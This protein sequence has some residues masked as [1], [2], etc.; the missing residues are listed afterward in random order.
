M[1]AFSQI[2]IPH[3]DIL[4]GKLTLDVFAADIW[5]VLSGKAPADYLDRD[6]FFSKTYTTKGLKNILD[7]AKRRLEGRG[8]DSVIQL[9]TP[10][11]G[12]KTHALIALYHQARKW[13]AKVC[14]FDGTALN[15]KES[16]PWEELEKQITG[17]VSITKGEIAPGKEKLIDLI[18]RNQ[19]VLILIDEILEY[20]TKAAGIRIGASNLA[21]QTMAF[22]Q[23]LS[24]AVGTVEKALLVLS[25]PSSI[26]EHYDENAEKLYGMLQKITGRTE[27]IYTPVEE[28]EIEHVIRKRLFQK[29]DE[30]AVKKVVDEFI[31]YA[32]TEGLLSQDEVQ[33]YREKFISSYPFKPEVVDVLYKK[34]GSFP[35]FQRTRGVLR[36]LSLVIFDLMDKKMPF[37]RLG[38]F[39]LGNNEIR[40][41]L[42][43]HIG[44][45][46]DSIIAQDITSSQAGSRFVDENIGNAYR[47]Y[48]LG[49]VVART[50]FMHS[51]SGKGEKGAGVREIK[52]S[53]SQPE[54]SSSVIDSVINGLREK[55][56]Y[57]ADEG[58]Y[59]SN[60]PNLN[61]VL[62]TREENI[63][64]EAIIEEERAY[65]EKFISKKGGFAVYIWAENHRDIPDTPELK[66]II[67]KDRKPEWEF[68]EK[69]GETPRIY[70][71]TLIFLAPDLNQR[72]IFHDYVRKLLALKSVDS[73]EK[74]SL[75]EGQKREIKNKIKNQ[76]QRAY[77][78]LR[79]CYRFVYLPVRND[80]KEVDL[81]FA[82]FGEAFIDKEIYNRLRNEGEI[83]ERL[84]AAV[85][86]EKYLQEKDSLPTK[87]LLESLW[88][89]PGEVR[90]TSAEGFKE[91]IKEGV[92]RGIFGLGFIE[93][94]KPV[95]KF[96]KQAVWP[97][98]S[99][100]E[101]ILKAELC[102]LAAGPEMP[103]GIVVGVEGKE[104]KEGEKVGEVEK[105]KEVSKGPI[106]KKIQLRLEIP[107][108]RLS[109]VARV[110]N[111]INTKF[112]NC[113]IEIS[114]RAEGGEISKSEYE[115]KVK[116]ALHQAAINIKEEDVD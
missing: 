31:S 19:P 30:V 102:R 9:Q 39:D 3:S 2:A 115:D 99:D 78:E 50:I 85:I 66:L 40:R 95:C 12:G 60:Q 47:A 24:G 15:P 21:A 51:F 34:W 44:S 113:H 22:L 36:L 72:P 23:E 11:G 13:G 68:V 103:R 49:T 67:L 62:L 64:R 48:K 58:L 57:L 90:L 82:T 100:G 79:K 10:F 77:E 28:D 33:R 106:I 5:Q 88:K 112:N 59:F 46:W 56:F 84:S 65:L 109:D 6:L 61:R 101:V 105:G 17:K 8:G 83:L 98:L 63:A 76:E 54:F 1:K 7:V 94:G 27:R 92:E 71:N 97:D 89:T 52:L 107:R 16:K 96:F 38:D 114:L 29:V 104:E 20:A 86:K 45:E 4:Q 25:L 116:E 111:Y 91:G 35:T 43:K 42:I 26:M 69:H 93:E 73:D 37:I 108:G 70:R 74:L 87:A 18:S 81:G 41:E 110:V 80:F 14:V 53:A 75:T 32:R 55:L